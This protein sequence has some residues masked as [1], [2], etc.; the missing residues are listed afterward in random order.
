M[1]IQNFIYLGALALI[2]GCGQTT[3][4]TNTETEM[5]KGA[6]IDLTNMNTEIKAGDDFFTY[7][8]G[9]WLEKNPMPEEY[10]RYGAFE[11][12][13]KKNQEE[14]KTIVE[15]IS[16]MESVEK[17]SPEQQIRDF[18]NAGMDTIRIEDLGIKPIEPLLN[19]I[20]ELTTKDELITVQAKLNF[21]GTYP[22]FVVFSSQDD[23]NSTEV[24]AN[25]MQG[26]LGLPDR[27]YY[28]RDDERTNNIRVEYVQH[29]N[30]MFVLA[31]YSETEA[32]IMA[33][34]VMGFETELAKASMTML[35]RRDPHATY[36]IYNL[37]KLKA[38]I[39]QY[40][41]E[42]YFNALNITQTEKINIRQPQFMASMDSLF[43]ATDIETLK[44][45]FLWNVLNSN[46]DKLNKDFVNQSFYF[47][48]TVLSGVDKMKPRWKK[49]ISSTNGNLGDPVGKIYVEKYFPAES[50]ERMVA[51]VRNLKLALGESINNL[52]WMSPETK[53]KAQEKL[54]SINLKVGY[55]NV[56]KDYS[57]VDINAETYVQNTWNCSSYS[58]KRNLDKIGKPVDREEW[59]MNPQTVNAYYSPN[60]NEIVFP[61]AILQPPFFDAEADD[62]VNYG[63]IGVVIGHEMTHGFDD[64]GRLYD[65]DGNLNEWW[66]EED[67]A[68]FKTKTQILVEQYNNYSILDSL[69]V[70]GELTLGENIADNG[71][72]YIAYAAL[73]MSY[74]QNG[75][76]SDID[77]LSSDQRF[78]I[79]YA[80]L[81]RQHIRPKTLMRRLQEDV[82]SP[83][84]ARVNAG[85]ANLPWWYSAF[86]VKE[87][88]ANYIAPENRAKIW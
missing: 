40:N 37:E 79:S 27:D 30:K 15:E 66:N 48:S 58:Y 12:L 59:G 73:Q 44:F 53:L 56:W 55:P 5:K 87:G 52:D 69:H 11:V 32:I 68:N 50:K 9:G 57:S 78:L 67:A 4:E 41:F 13:G 10:S 63:A 47:Y 29:L 6:G 62:A 21:I 82:H 43:A 3:N 84:D 8:N 20:K 46:A 81:W 33:D 76:A 49:M 18:Y 16:A 36:N 86:D 75:E 65:K 83:G 42:A 45:Y 2:A 35:E 72:L 7:A 24:I 19:E 60:M 34:K 61:A 39:P 74:E 77:G 22:L 26:G 25:M 17:G 64:Q 88:D 14:I 28:T 23:K 71:G 38:E 31:A 1:K 70:D 85:V 80:Q 54:G 51:L